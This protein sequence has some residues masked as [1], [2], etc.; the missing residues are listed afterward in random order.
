M[1]VLFILLSTQILTIF[2]LSRM[3][4]GESENLKTMKENGPH[5]TRDMKREGEI[6][7]RLATEID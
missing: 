7:P 1:Q 6:G 3:I 5:L 4:R 2:P